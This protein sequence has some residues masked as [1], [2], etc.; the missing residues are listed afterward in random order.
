MREICILRTTIPAS[1]IDKALK[2]GWLLAA[3][4]IVILVYSGTFFS[5]TALK[6]WGWVLFL[7][8]FACLTYGLLPY[9]RLSRL[10]LKPNELHCIGSESLEYYS[11]GQHMLT[12][13][14]KDIEEL[15]YV[16]EAGV[17]GISVRLKRALANSDVQHHAFN[18]NFFQKQAIKVQSDEK[19]FFPYFSKRSFEELQ[20]WLIEED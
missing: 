12:L 9:Q 2:R 1:L 15:C 6:Q 16:E 3:L 7:A 20:T 18:R 19:V 13:A 17:F 8:G 4:G 5:L 10:Q 11:S 14:F